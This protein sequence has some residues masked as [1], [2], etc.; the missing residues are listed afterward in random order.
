MPECPYCT[1]S[2][3]GP[4]YFA[5][6]V[7]KTKELQIKTVILHNMT[8][9]GKDPIEEK[10]KTYQVFKNRKLASTNEL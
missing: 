1:H 9:F 2:Y 10:K 8:S 5:H 4:Q 3:K 6:C 7:G